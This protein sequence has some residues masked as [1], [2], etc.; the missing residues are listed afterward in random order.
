MIA[1]VT[2][3]KLIVPLTVLVA[4]EVAGQ[5][6]TLPTY[7]S[8][9]SAIAA[10][11]VELTLTGELPTGLAVSL[12]R[13]YAGFALGASLGVIAGLAAGMSTGVR[14][15]FDPI[16]SF[17]YPIPKITFLSIFLLLFGLGNGSQIAIVSFGVFFPVFVASRQA[18]RSVNRL[19]VWAGQNM[20]APRTTVFFRVVVPAAAP[21]L[22]SGLRVGLAHSFVV[23]FAAELI[24]A[25]NGLGYLI[26]EGEEAVRF[27]MMLSAIVAFA[28][29]GFASDRILMAVRRSVLRGQT[30]GT[31]E[32][33]P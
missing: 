14:N 9:P 27:D 19:F 23:L 28:A 11:I 8:R 31:Q 30:L 18:V 29:I 4:W 21:M 33:M 32:Q 1:R 7:L 3:E 12:V 2:L 17:L 6:G 24:G 5:I 20:G 25:R 15:F 26:V 22:F 13:A 16:V 10:A